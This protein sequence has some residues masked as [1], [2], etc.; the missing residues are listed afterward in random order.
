MNKKFTLPPDK[1]LVDALKLGPSG[2]SPKMSLQIISELQDKLRESE[3]KLSSMSKKVSRL[4]QENNDLLILA[5]EKDKEL[6]KLSEELLHTRRSSKLKETNEMFSRP[7]P[8]TPSKSSNLHKMRNFYLEK[9]NKIETEVKTFKAIFEE[10]KKLVENKLKIY[11]EREIDFLKKIKTLED[12]VQGLEVQIQV[13]KSQEISQKWEKLEEENKDLK[14]QLEIIRKAHNL[15]DLAMLSPDI[16][17]ISYQVSQLLAILQSLRS[18]KDVSLKILLSTD[19]TNPVNSSKQLIFDV[20]ELKK[21]LSLIKQIVSDYHA[22]H[23]GFS[24]C[25]TQ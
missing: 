25:I 16:H 14:K 1:S 15:H 12:L 18:G 24:L 17:Q 7:Y 10:E 11:S 13:M 8:K 3:L 20:N 21:N 23:L 5:T 2:T 9:S 22:E 4:E 6:Q 19:E